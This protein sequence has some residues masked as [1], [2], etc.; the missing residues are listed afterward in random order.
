MFLYLSWLTRLP[1]NFYSLY[2][3]TPLAILPLGK[4]WEESGRFLTFSPF[5]LSCGFHPSGGIAKVGAKQHGIWT[6]SFCP[7]FW[8]FVFVCSHLFHGSASLQPPPIYLRDNL[9]VG[10]GFFCLPFPLSPHWVVLF[11]RFG[12]LEHKIGYGPYGIRI[13][14]FIEYI[15]ML[16]LSWLF[17]IIQKCFR[18]CPF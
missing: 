1:Q 13:F 3:P 8:I 9:A 12:I 7:T 10:V 5:V 6:L 2:Y 16:L 11:M 4:L 17:F 15:K 18:K 14:I